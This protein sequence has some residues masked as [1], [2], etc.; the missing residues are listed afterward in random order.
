MGARLRQLVASALHRYPLYAGCGRIANTTL[1]RRLA[2]LAPGEVVPARLRDGARLLV[3]TDDFVGRAVMYFGDLDPKVTWVCDRLL[4]PGDV[5]VDIGANLG[6]V[7]LLASAR[8]GATGH[9]HAFE[10]QPRLLE[11][12]HASLQLN[13][14]RN[15]TV[16]GVALGEREGRQTLEIPLH[17]RGAASLQ[18]HAVGDQSIEVPVCTLSACLKTENARSVRLVKLDVEGYEGQVLQGAEPLLQSTPP[19]AVLFECKGTTAFWERPEVDLLHR[20]GYRFLAP[21]GRFGRPRFRPVLR[22]VQRLPAHDV[23]AVHARAFDDV[24]QAL[25]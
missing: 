2:A 21:R 3:P 24:V 25:A 23:L 14:R 9:V 8:V 4:R 5:M 17:N 1:L 6:L 18:R 13:G 19:D 16:H 11:W 22:S 7:T 10:P 12:L 15:V 20:H